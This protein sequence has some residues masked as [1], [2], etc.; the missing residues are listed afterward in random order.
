MINFT[1]SDFQQLSD[2]EAKLKQSL[3]LK[4]KKEEEM[5]SPS[6]QSVQNVLAYSKALSL[7]KSNQVDYIENILN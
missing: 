5:Q 6:S 7:R 4:S 3:H 2:D 1:F